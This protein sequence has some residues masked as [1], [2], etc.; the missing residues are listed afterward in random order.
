MNYPKKTKII[1]T[2]GPS[3]NSLEMLT[4]LIANGMDVARLNFSHGDYDFFK[5]LV[6]NI[7]IASKLA[8]REIAVLQDL[9]GPK[10]RTGKVENGA[11]ELKEGQSF[12]ITTDDLEIGNNKIVST[13][14]KNLPKE[15]KVNS[16]LLIDDGYL[17]FKVKNI[18]KN[19]VECIVIKGGKL[20]DKKGIIAPGISFSAPAISEKDLE[21]LK[22]GLSLGIDL[23]ALSFVSSS[24]DIL[25]LK[26]TQKIFG[27]QVPIIAKIERPEAIKNIDEIIDES[28]GI[29]IARGDLGLEFPVEDV[30]L[31]QKNIITKC[32]AKSKPV[33][34]ATQMLESMI[35]NLRPTRAEATDVANAVIDGSDALMLSGETSVGTYPKEALNTMFNIIK[36]TEDNI[37]N[38]P[39]GDKLFTNLKNDLNESLAHAS[40]VIAE[41]MNAS[42]IITIATDI[43]LIKDI[44][45]FRPRIPIIGLSNNLELIRQMNLIW[46]VIPTYINKLDSFDDFYKFFLNNKEKFNY[47]ANESYIVFVSGYNN[48]TFDNMI[49]VNQIIF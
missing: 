10:I 40:T 38:I 2:I 49:K 39:Y 14:Y 8:N 37:Y 28:D 27:R 3:S 11:V 25:E 36:K 16:T 12:T 48:L 20:K 42:A 18:T 7:R 5:T 4:T 43:N 6:N 30:P 1:C 47:I 41:Q 45:K 15:L 46:G 23:V 17:I 26:T 31:L 21:D 22:F 19:D 13:S 33:I 35:S 9:Q 44:S 32:N 24:R 29:M 34:T